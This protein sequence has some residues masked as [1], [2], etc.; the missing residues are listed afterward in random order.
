M[1]SLVQSGLRPLILLL[2]QTQLSN[3]SWKMKYLTHNQH[4]MSLYFLLRPNYTHK[5]KQYTR[6]TIFTLIHLHLLRFTIKCFEVYYRYFHFFFSYGFCFTLTIKLERTLSLSNNFYKKK[7]L[8]DIQ[9]NTHGR[10]CFKCVLINFCYFQSGNT[11]FLLLWT[12]HFLRS[13]AE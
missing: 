5:I 12:H 6:L 3:G 9:Q 8:L 10:K 2:G 1:I 11:L 7:E 13:V 4:L